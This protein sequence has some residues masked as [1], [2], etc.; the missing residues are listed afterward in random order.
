MLQVDRYVCVCVCVCGGGESMCTPVC[1]R[2]CKSVCVCVG[3]CVCVKSYMSVCAGACVCNFYVC[4]CV[5]STGVCVFLT[6]V[7]CVQR[8]QREFPS[9]AQGD[10]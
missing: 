4:V 5:K 8:V 2:E 3:V 7:Q 6:T 9:C 10:V 1:E